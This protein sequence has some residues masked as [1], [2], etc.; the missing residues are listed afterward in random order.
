[1]TSINNTQEQHR[2]Q[3]SAAL[4]ELLRT[5]DLVALVETVT[6]KTGRGLY[7]CPDP[8]HQDST[9]SLSVFVGNDGKHRFKC[10]GCGVAGDAVNFLQWTRGLTFPQ[11]VDML[12][13]F[14]GVWDLAPKKAQNP[15]PKKTEPVTLEPVQDTDTRADP[16]TSA[17]VLDRY[18]ALRGWPQHLAKVH[19]LSVVRRSGALWVRHPYLVPDSDLEESHWMSYQ[20]RAWPLPTGKWWNPAGQP[21]PLF[22]LEQFLH[23]PAPQVVFLVEGAPDCI[24]ARH[25]LSHYPDISAVVLGVPGSLSL[26]KWWEVLEVPTVVL[27]F[28]PDP[29]GAK[30]AEKA[31]TVLR[32]FC[33]A[34]CVL[35]TDPWWV[36][37]HQVKD[38]TELLAT[39]AGLHLVAAQLLEPLH[40]K[41]V[42]RHDN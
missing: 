38:I 11:A 28:D 37:A 18:C 32:K 23:T 13:S 31:R 3:S 4:S 29:A 36:T 12:R 22:G 42:N 33:P 14:A 21:L 16:A 2:H 10:H 1:M 7:H 20:D 25:A 30:H 34:T 19:Q 9:G 39:P 8:D 6:G 41:E 26:D 17:E 27:A 15:A 40:Q 35:S 5:V 24:T